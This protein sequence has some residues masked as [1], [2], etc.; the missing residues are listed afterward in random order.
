MPEPVVRTAA[1]IEAELQQVD[2]NAAKTPEE[3]QAEID[4]ELQTP[5]TKEKAIDYDLEAGRKGWVPKDKY[6]GDPA[7][8]VDAKTFVERGERFASNLQREVEQLKARLEKF[9]GNAKAFAEFSKKQLEQ[10]DQELKQALA[11]LRIERARA[12]REGEDV[13]VSELDDKIDSVKAQVKEVKAID[14]EEARQQV[15]P[16]LLEWI[17]DGNSW[18]KDDAKLRDYAVQV[19]VEM[20][21]AGETLKGRKFFDLVRARMEE[22]FP[23]RFKKAEEGA[24]GSGTNLVEGDGGPSGR[25]STGYKGKSEKDLPAEDLALMK[26]YIKEGWTTREKFLESYFSRN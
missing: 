24:K 2:H 20:R 3:I 12:I 15:D 23:R 9:E 6:K 17:E 13:L 5:S 26:E 11:D 16:V 7:K 25:G 22:D 1:E 21:S 8:W 4:A 10:K 19:G 18:F 14:P